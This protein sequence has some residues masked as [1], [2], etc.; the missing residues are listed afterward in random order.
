MNGVTRSLGPQSLKPGTVF[1]CVAFGAYSFETDG[2]LIYQTNF[3]FTTRASH[4]DL[5]ACL[6]VAKTM[7]R[8]ESR[9]RRI[10]RRS[11]T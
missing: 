8:A 9:K 4:S 7:S 1:D 10:R 3:N 11:T 5:D 2:Q 6:R